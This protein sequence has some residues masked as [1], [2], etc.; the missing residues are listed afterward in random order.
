MR[1]EWDEDKNRKNL[2]KHDIRFETAALVFEDPHALTQRDLFSEDEERWVTL[3]T[4]GSSTILFVVH[5]WLHVDDEETIRIISA[6][7]ATPRER[8]TYEEAY[9]G[10]KAGHRGHREQERRRH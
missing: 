4:I 9:Q 2:H 3:G 5:T 7:A 10:T 1:L 8:R 6:R